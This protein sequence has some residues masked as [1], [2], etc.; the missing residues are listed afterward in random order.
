MKKILLLCMLASLVFSCK[1]DHAP[2]PL[3][4]I[5]GTLLFSDPASDGAGL[6]FDTDEGEFLLFKN[7]FSDYNAQYQHYI[8]FIG[9]YSRLSFIDRGETGCTFGMLPCAQQ[10]PLRLV[11]VVKLEKE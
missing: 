7:I 10:H 3:Q 2:V 5:T 11:E 9:V 4:Y 8:D 6:Y 1:K